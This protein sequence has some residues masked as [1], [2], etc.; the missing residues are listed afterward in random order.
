MTKIIG[1][2]VLTLLCLCALIGPLQGC[3]PGDPQ[4]TPTAFTDV[5]SFKDEGGNRIYTWELTADV[6]TQTVRE[7][8]ENLEFSA[9]FLTAAYFYPEDAVIP[10]HSVSLASGV[11]QANGAIYKARGF[12]PWRYAYVRTPEGAVRFVDCQQ[13]PDDELCHKQ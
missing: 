12:S 1:L 3:S 5:A 7:Y 11:E 9:G 6:S 10:L 4:S 2:S 8:A 13:T